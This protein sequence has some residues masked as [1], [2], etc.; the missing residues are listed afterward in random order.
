MKWS[1]ETNIVIWNGS[2]LIW[3][4]FSHINMEMTFSGGGW[5]CLDANYDEYQLL[6][7]KCRKILMHHSVIFK[8][9]PLTLQSLKS[10]MLWIWGWWH[11]LR[12]INHANTHLEN[13]WLVCFLEMIQKG[14]ALVSLAQYTA[15]IKKTWLWNGSNRC[16]IF[17]SISFKKLFCTARNCFMLCWHKHV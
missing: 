7:M 1:L 3:V 9:V 2:L 11:C 17:D 4:L 14:L 12:C 5:L 8:L 16:F 13:K 10:H 15:R 6:F